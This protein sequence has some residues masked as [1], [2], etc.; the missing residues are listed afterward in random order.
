MFAYIS[1]NSFIENYFIYFLFGLFLF[2]SYLFVLVGSFVCDFRFRYFFL[3]FLF[4]VAN[5]LFTNYSMFVNKDVN[6][7]SVENPS[8]YIIIQAP[9]VNHFSVENAV[10]P[11]KGVTHFSVDNINPTFLFRPWS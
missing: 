10:G 5:F 6:H 9:H 1:I 8:L 7:F 2:V 4:F 11:H 3:V